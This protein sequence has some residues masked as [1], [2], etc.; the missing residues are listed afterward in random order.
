[1]GIFIGDQ[2]VT[3]AYLG[4]LPISTSA[5][6][7]SISSASIE[8][9]IVG[10]GGGG[11]GNVGGGGGAGGLLS[12][13]TSITGS[14]FEIVVGFGGEP[15][16]LSSSVVYI[17]GTN[18]GNSD[19]FGFTAYG[20][21]YGGSNTGWPI[22]LRSGSDGGSGGGSTYGLVQPN[23]GSGIP[24]QGFDG[25]VGV[26]IASPPN[27][28]AGG[29]GGASQKGENGNLTAGLG[30]NGG[31]G[32]PSAITG[33][34]TYYAG[35]GGAGRSRTGETA[36][37]Q[38]GLGGGGNGGWDIESQNNPSGDPTA[39]SP[40]T[41]GGGGGGSSGNLTP[42]DRLGPG[43]SGIVVV[44]YLGPQKFGGGD[45]VYYDGSYVVHKFTSVGTGYLYAL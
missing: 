35:G 22:G 20:G 5:Q 43:G 37:A 8:Y 17:N 39:G 23:S 18:G 14:I 29:G 11:G 26:Y 16:Y 4:T 21:G 7:L 41:G 27:L 2:T 28:T 24:G 40:N 13:S 45:E 32:L 19:A 15:S 12:G 3:M 33:T 34:L 31:D 10:G 42:G 36:A 25:G 44:R 6:T 30:G 38:G 9:L 1:M